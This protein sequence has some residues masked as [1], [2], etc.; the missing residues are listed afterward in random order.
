MLDDFE[1]GSC[2]FGETDES[3]NYLERFEIVWFLFLALNLPIP[4]PLD[5]CIQYIIYNSAYIC[6]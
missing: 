4:L 3:K 5:K 2:L 6:V 1:I